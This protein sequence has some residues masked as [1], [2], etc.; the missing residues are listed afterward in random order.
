MLAYE[1]GHALEPALAGL[2]RTG[3]GPLVH[4]GIYDAPQEATGTLARAQTEAAGAGLTAPVPTLP[5]AAHAA[6]IA[7]AL[8]LIRA[9]DCYQ[10]NLTFPL[11]ATAR[12]T[13]LGL[14]AA[15]SRVQPVGHGAVVALPDAPALVS[16]SPESF[17]AT[18][19]AGGITV[20]PMKGTRPRHPDP[21]QDAALAA[22]LRAAV[23]DRAEN[24]MIVDLMRNDLSRICRV[25]S[26]KVPRLFDVESY[27]TVHQM[28]S[29]VR[30]QLLPGTGLA[31]ILRAIFP[32]GSITGAPK[33]RAMQILHELEPAPRGAY[34]GAIGWAGPDGAS[35]FNV[36]IRTLTLCPGGA[37]TLNVGGGVVADSTADGE[38]EEALW[39]ARFARV[40]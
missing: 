6:A 23:K 7:R 4:L 20:R 5:R 14:Y 30:G 1:A 32:C 31:G 33:I 39:K 36:A 8:E 25:G 2:Q 26:V 29:E 24:L 16:L 21:A 37:V 13:P 10:V 35:A 18:D 9:G 19:A 27:A 40:S 3:T 38:W 11:T 28:V 17:F 22:D 12:G 34:C 15:L